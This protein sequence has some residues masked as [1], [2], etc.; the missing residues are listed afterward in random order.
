MLFLNG[1]MI[2]ALL[3]GYAGRLILGNT[4]AIPAGF[5]GTPQRVKY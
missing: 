1:G 3:T 4:L 5:D 2:Q